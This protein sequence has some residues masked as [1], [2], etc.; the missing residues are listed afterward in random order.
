MLWAFK[1][2]SFV[3][4]VIQAQLQASEHINAEKQDK[5]QHQFLSQDGS[6]EAFQ[7]TEP[8]LNPQPPGSEHDCV[9]TQ[10]LMQHVFGFSYGHPFVG[11]YTPP[12]CSFNRVTMNFT[13]TSSG[14][15]FDRLG[16]M[17]LGDVEVFR[18][19][20]AEPGG[21]KVEWSYVKQMDQYYT[22]WR[23]PQRI[24]FDL[25]NLIDEKY[26]GAFNASLSATF[27]TVLDAGPYADII[28]PIS[29]RL[30]NDS[31]GSAFSLPADEANV[32][33]KLPRNVNRA[34]ISIAANG[35]SSGEEFWYT[36]TLGGLEETFQPTIGRLNGHGS[37]R[38]ILLY[39]DDHLAGQ[40]L[41]F[42]VIFTGG[43]VPGLWRRIVG[44]QTFDLIEH[45]IDV[46]P[47][48]PLLCD[49]KP[50][51]FAIKVVGWGITR[52]QYGSIYVPSDTNAY[53][54]VTGKIF[55]YLDEAGSITT[56]TEPVT[57]IERGDFDLAYGV[58]VDP[59]TA[60]NESLFWLMES[61]PRFAL[62]NKARLQL[63]LGSW[64]VETIQRYAISSENYIT[65]KGFD[66]RTLLE[67]Q[68]EDTTTRRFMNE[69]VNNEEIVYHRKYSHALNMS[70]L[71][72]E[73]SNI[74]TIEA[75]INEF[76]FESAVTGTSV[77]PTGLEIEDELPGVQSVSR[78]AE[79]SQQQVVLQD[80]NRLATDHL[81]AKL[82]TSLRGYGMY[83]SGKNHS[84]SLGNTRQTYVFG[85]APDIDESGGEIIYS[86][87]VE[88]QLKEVI[89]DE[90]RLDGKPIHRDDI[91]TTMQNEHFESGPH[92]TRSIRDILGRGP[93][94][95][96]HTDVQQRQATSNT[97]NG[98]NFRQWTAQAF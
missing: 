80:P 30:S 3:I 14:V 81:V 42:P 15:Q 69:S 95:V 73:K 54:V 13:V 27:Y 71:F 38:R 34:V 65:D 7:V 2:G 97:R 45:E 72:R 66:Q 63:S 94:L 77:F 16:I 31:K 44:I 92:D 61:T 43:I 25:G 52:N 59:K 37:D 58:A 90:E 18:T 67:H 9:Y 11:Q 62:I 17:Y 28:F 76:S 75:T 5:W 20:T 36:N 4:A 56:G 32:T 35:Q 55:L 21:G 88:A 85:R 64:D 93:G 8:V 46:T 84:F 91:L 29:R 89:R 24:V 70:T 19:S 22:L 68:G 50:H 12:P 6:V 51:V 49:G 57:R 39:I 1:L 74:F 87:S 48:L 10:L 47:F 41:P 79:M 82:A 78:R 33:Y 40:V 98:N 86:R 60:L 23:E 53:W 26:T 96:S 83:V